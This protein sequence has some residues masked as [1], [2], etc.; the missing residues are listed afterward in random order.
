MTAGRGICQTCGSE[1][2]VHEGPIHQPFFC[3]NCGGTNIKAATVEVTCDDCGKQ[4]DIPRWQF[5]E[6]IQFEQVWTCEACQAEPSSGTERAD[7]TMRR[8]DWLALQVA[9][10]M[11]GL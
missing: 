5:E 4:F 3:K 11:L 2:I 9:F 8:E 6:D 1:D 10:W 7:F